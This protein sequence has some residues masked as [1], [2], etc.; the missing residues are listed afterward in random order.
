LRHAFSAK[1]FIFLFPFLFLF[2]FAA[3]SFAADT[4]QLLSQGSAKAIE[5]LPKA[6]T[7]A[8]ASVNNTQADPSIGSKPVAL[9]ININGASDPTDL[10]M[11]LQLML[12]MTLLSVAPSLIMLTTSFTRIVIV[13]SFVKN[14][15][16]VQQAPSSQIIVGL[17]LFLTFFIMQP[18]WD[19]IYKNAVVPYQN[20]T[21]TSQ[22]AFGRGCDALKGFMLKQTRSSDIEFF[23]RVSHSGPTKVEDL[24]IHIVMPAFIMSELRTAF[25]MGFLIF[26]PFIIIDFIVGCSLMS[27]GMMMM[28]PAVISTPFKILLFVLIDGWSLIVQSLVQSFRV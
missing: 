8:A 17:A 6:T 3:P 14:A 16:G 26:I 4:P 9:S 5:S 1:L 18:V 27:M 20:K 12:M 23:L 2:A 11:A 22:V 21:I 13:L 7:P 25:Q 15:I 10:S 28:P 19:N 24:P